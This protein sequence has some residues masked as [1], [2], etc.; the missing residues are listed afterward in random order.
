[1]RKTRASDQLLVAGG[2]VEHTNFAAEVLQG[3]D[4]AETE[5]RKA[6]QRQPGT[7]QYIVGYTHGETAS[8][9]LG[10]L[11]LHVIVES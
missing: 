11:A 6:F 3:M 4:R 8:V 7:S 2:R 1:M 10:G 9:C 5:Q